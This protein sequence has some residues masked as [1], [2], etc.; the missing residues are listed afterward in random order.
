MK[1]VKFGVS[2]HFPEN[3]WRKWPEILHADVSW[4]PSELNSLWARSVDFSNFSAI[5]TWWNR[6]NLGFPGISRRTH[7]GNGLKFCTLMYRDHLQ[8]W[9]VYGHGLL[10][11]L[12]LVLFWL[13]EMGRIWDFRAFP[14]THIIAVLVHGVG[15]TKALFV[16]FSIGKIWEYLLDYWIT[17][18]FDTC[19]C[20]SAAVTPVKYKCDIQQLTIVFVNAEKI[21]KIMEWKKLV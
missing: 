8:N 4:P 12:I 13:S 15:V 20:S 6:S 14:V 17:F 2:G 18:I 16:N 19:H 9:F 21:Q 11:F 7:G 1:Q 10:I 3:A 5:L